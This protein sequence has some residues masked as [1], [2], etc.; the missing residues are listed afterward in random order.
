MR[1]LFAPEKEKTCQKDDTKKGELRE[2]PP[3]SLG[4]RTTSS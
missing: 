4:G 3:L 1:L 2:S